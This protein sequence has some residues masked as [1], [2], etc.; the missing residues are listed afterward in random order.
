MARARGGWT[1][2]WSCAAAACSR[3]QQPQRYE[4]L[5]CRAGHW[6]SPAACLPSM[7]PCLPLLPAPQ[8]TRCSTRP[9]TPLLAPTPLPPWPSLPRRPRAVPRALQQAGAE[10]LCPPH[11][12]RL[13]Q[14]SLLLSLLCLIHSSCLE[15][16]GLRKKA[17]HRQLHACCMQVEASPQHTLPPPFPPPFPHPCRHGDAPEALAAGGKW[18]L[19]DG[20]HPRPPMQMPPELE[21]ALVAHAFPTYDRKVGEVQIGWDTVGTSAHL[22]KPRAESAGTAP[23]VPTKRTHAA[24]L[25][26]LPLCSVPSPR[27]PPHHTCRC[28]PPLVWHASAAT[29]TPP[30][31]GPASR[32]WAV[33]PLTVV[34]CCLETS[35]LLPA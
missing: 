11:V 21:K 18:D 17:L 28:G 33:L 3:L 24:S 25:L 19:G 30:Q 7:L 20:S 22:C 34:C 27:P 8:T 32:R 29:C 1:D 23:L 26:T 5:P 16:R 35:R 15:N 2:A 31:S 14:V 6:A 4:R 9:T 13:L 12:P 10:G